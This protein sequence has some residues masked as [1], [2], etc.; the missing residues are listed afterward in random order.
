MDAVKV[1]PQ[2]AVI[3]QGEAIAWFVEQGEASRFIRNLYPLTQE[4]F[5]VVK[6]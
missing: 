3:W 5:E 2:Y 6:L 1:N 4:A